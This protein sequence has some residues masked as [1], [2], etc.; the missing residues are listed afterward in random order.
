VQLGSTAEAMLLSLALAARL[1]ILERDKRTALAQQMRA[2]AT[3]RALRETNELKT[4]LLGMAA[5]DLRNPLDA[6]LGYVEMLRDAAA[7]DAKEEVER[8]GEA[9]LGMN[10]LLADLLSAA[11]IESG[12]IELNRQRVPLAPLIAGVASAYRVL[13]ERK[14]QRI[15]V[16]IATADSTI[17]GDEARLREVLDNLV[18][19]AVKFTPPGGRIAVSLSASDGHL[20]LAV[21]DTGPGLTADDRQHLFQ[22]FERLSAR[23][24]ANEPS[25][26]LGLSIAKKIVELHGGRI[27]AES[28]PGAGSTF[29]VELPA[30]ETPRRA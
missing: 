12:R 10:A 6:I 15:D 3:T 9:A 19:N 16:D 25:T 20:R 5:H 21:R 1:R 28:T 7:P 14:G 27:W 29:V 18:S 4:Q 11:A 2:E 17:D 26:G 8:M 22:A 30:A 23:P 24:T 13:A